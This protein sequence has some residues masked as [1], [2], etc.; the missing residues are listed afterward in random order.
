MKSNKLFLILLSFVLSVTLLVACT[1]DEKPA[2]GESDTAPSE[3]NA[4]TDTADTA[5][6]GTAA[7]DTDTDDTADTSDTV[8]TADTADTAETSEDGTASSDEETGTDAITDGDTTPEET[9]A[10]LPRYDYFEEEVN[11]ISQATIS[12]SVRLSETSN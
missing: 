11:S 5:D 9:E 2:D 7:L 4:S 8:D 6:E 1:Q 3:T 12:S 10:P